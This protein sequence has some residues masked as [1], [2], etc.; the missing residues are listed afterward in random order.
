MKIILI[1]STNNIQSGY[2]NLTHELCMF[3][4]GKVDFTLL[5]PHDEQRYP[6]TSYPVEYILPSYIFNLR[7]SKVLQYLLFKYKTDADIVHSVFEFPYAL[8]AA[9][10]AKK[11]KKPLIIGLAGTYAVKPLFQFPDSIFLRRAYN[12]AKS[13]ISISQFNRDMVKKYSETKTP[14]NIIHPAVNFE[15][16]SRVYDENIVRQRYHDKKILMTVGALK[17]RKG[18]DIVLRALSIL[19]KE[20]NDF[21][22]HREKFLQLFIYVTT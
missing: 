6:Y 19:K 1:S 15:R 21:I 9:R 11:N 7:T 8:I 10:I 18:H 13:M 3:L 2:G 17:P 16:F 14:I 5:L 22:L 12:Q 4:K 20:R